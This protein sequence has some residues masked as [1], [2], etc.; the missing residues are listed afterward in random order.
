[1]VLETGDK[2]DAYRITGELGR[3]GMGVVY[4]AY[5]ETLRREAVIKMALP[6][7]SS[8][9]GRRRFLREAAAA[10]RCDHPGIV[11]VYSFGEHDG[12]PYMAMEYVEGKNLLDFLELAKA[13]TSSG[14]A[15]EL[16]RYGYIRDPEPGD[17]DLPYFL[18]PV[19]GPPLDDQDYENRAAALIAG[20][21][22]ALY[23][24]HSMGIL[25]RDIKPSNILIGAKGQAKLADFGLAKISDSS[26]ITT[27]QPMLGTLKYMPPESFSGKETS[28][29]SDIYSLG[30]VLY[31]LM[32]LEHPFKADNT[33]A[34]IKA[35][36]GNKCPP[37]SKFNPSVSPALALVIMKCLEKSPSARFR[38]AR[39]LA[40]AIRL[41]ARPKGLKTNIMDGIMGLL[42]SPEREHED[43]PGDEGRPVKVT[44]ESRSRAA[45]LVKEAQRLYFAEFAPTRAH[46]LILDALKLDPYSTDVVA[47]LALLS[48]HIGVISSLRRSLPRMRR[49]ARSGPDK[50]TRRRASLLADRI[51]SNKDWLRN[52]EKYLSEGHEDP[53]LLGLAARGRMS[54][55]DSSRASAYASRIE[56][57]IPGASLFSWFIEAYHT[58]WMGGHEKYLEITRESIRRFPDNVMVRYAL[59]QSLLESGRLQEAEKA[60]YEADKMPGHDDFFIY[61]K[62]ELALMRGRYKDACVEMRKFIGAAPE[63]LM[64]A[65]YYRLSRLYALRGDRK[66]ALRHLEIGR[67]MAPELNLKS[68]EE[69]SAL[70][71]GSVD[72][73]P[74]FDDLPP[75][76]LEFNFRKG[77]EALLK[78]MLGSFN[79]AG[80]AHSTVYIFEKNSPPLAVRNWLFFNEHHL[81]PARRNMIFLPALPLSSFM[82]MRGNALK[83]EFMRTHSDYGKY[84]ATLYYA[85]PLK[86][87]G[88][89]PVEVQLNTE[90]VCRE[91]RDGQLELRVDEYSNKLAY[92]C[93]I[94]AIPA[95]TETLHLSSKPDE[96]IRLGEWRYLVYSRFFFDRERFRLNARFSHREARR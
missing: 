17:E 26:D 72:Y 93:H 75:E 38:D 16:R 23:E 80:D 1:M 40:D 33:A 44:A 50:D 57:V 4:K 65:A 94:A 58:A 64:A 42:R 54:G 31:E 92:R 2:L 87:L 73:R 12:L 96:D 45:G 32:T 9:T 41:A 89:Y 19:S 20:V 27:G 36:T 78:R 56:R 25:H 61:L 21:A 90:G 79:N 83:S 35:V 74:S 6:G 34:F 37:P 60:M 15:E 13:V 49:L 43:L 55:A 39:E 77:R 71:E 91:R 51:E 7:Q 76:C 81:T 18:R 63:D 22:D 85:A 29:A 24:A 48:Y 84:V 62:A 66:E 10:A 11:K 86:H 88:L 30:T 69:L 95:D 59:A 46:S 67:N 53:A 52:L 47:M 3:G 14:D 70:V 28:P 68:N 82:D 5:D 8:R